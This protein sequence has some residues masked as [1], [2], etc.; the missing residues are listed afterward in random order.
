[1]SKRSAFVIGK[2]GTVKYAWVTDDPKVQVDFEAIKTA[3][4]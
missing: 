2:D 3:L 4:K 1:V